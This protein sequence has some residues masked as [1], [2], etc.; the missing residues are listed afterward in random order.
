MGR[1]SHF[2]TYVCAV[3]LAVAGGA[4]CEGS[5]PGGNTGLG[6]QD[7]ISAGEQD[8]G[9]G[10]LPDLGGSGT[11]TDPGGPTPCPA[12]A[13]GPGTKAEDTDGDGCIDHCSAC[14]DVTC[15]E[16]EV[17]VDLDEDGCVD[18]CE[19]CPDLPCEA[20]AA[21]DT[22]EDG[23]PDACLPCE[24]FSCEGGQGALDSDG[25]GCVDACEDCPVT[26]PCPPGSM[27][28]DTDG[29]GCVDGCVDCLDLSCPPG[30]LGA[31]TDGNGCPDTCEP[32]PQILCPFATSALDEDGDGCDD[33]CAPCPPLECDPGLVAVDGD[34]DGCPDDCKECP[35]L[36]CGP[37][38]AAGDVD[39]D[40][41]VD[42]CTAC[43]PMEPCWPGTIPADLDGDG[44][45][46]ECTPCVDI[47]CEPGSTAVDTNGDGCD[48]G[49]RA[50]AQILCTPGTHPTDVDGDGCPDRCQLCPRLEC[51]P[52]EAPV[53]A[54][55]DRC[56]DTCKACEVPLCEPGSE[57]VDLDGDGC[58]ETCVSCQ[59]LPC[60]GGEFPVDTDGDGCA[61]ECA[62]CAPV[63]CRPGE[64]EID[65]DG[66]GCVDGCKPCDMV[67]CPP[68]TSAEDTDGDGCADAC[69]PCRRPLCRPGTLPVD[70]DGDGCRDTC[71]PCPPLQCREGT[72]PVDTDDD[73]CHDACRPCPGVLCPEGSVPVD[74]DGDSCE[75][76]CAPCGPLACPPD[77]EARDTDG[78]GCE[79]ACVPRRCRSNEDCRA[80]EY[81][82][83]RPGQCDDAGTCRAR[84]QA[85]T[86]ELDP[87]CG[88][89]GE[90]YGNACEAAVAGTGILHKGRCERECGAVSG[91]ICPDGEYCDLEPGMCAATGLA[92]VCRSV[93]E[94]CLGLPVAPV[95][96]CN[97]KTH[98]N[99]C[100]RHRAQ[101]QKMHDGPCSCEPL[102]C[103]HGTIPADTDNDACPDTC[104][105]CPLI[106]C[107]PGTVPVDVDGDGCMDEC[108]PCEEILC[109]DGSIPA[110]TD[111][112][113]CPDSCERLKCETNRDCPRA[114]Y[115]AAA[116]T[117]DCGSP[118]LCARR[119]D[120]CIDLYSPVCGCDGLTYGNACS[121]AAAG[122]RVMSRGE[123]ECRPIR[124]PDGSRPADTDGDGCDDE[125]IPC[126]QIVCL[127][128]TEPVD[129]NDD[130]CADVCTAPCNEQC[131]CYYNE[132]LE[133]PRPCPQ[134]CADCG[135]FWTCVEGACV[136][137]CGRIPPE[138]QDCVEPGWCE[139]NGD[140]ADFEIC[141]REPGRCEGP[142]WCEPRPDGCFDFYA[143]VCG[144]NGQTYENDCFASAEGQNV[145]HEG[146]CE[147]QQPCGGF[148]G[149]PCPG[150]Q[151]CD[152]PPGL[153]FI[154]D[155]G[156]VC[157]ERPDG[158]DDVWE[159]VCSCD[160]ETYPNDC[161]RLMQGAAK[162]HDGPCEC[163][164]ILC[165][166][167]TRPV[168][169]DFDGC[170]DDCLPCRPVDC[171]AGTVPV[172]LN[173][174]GCDDDCEPCPEIVCTGGMPV[175]FDGDGCDDFCMPCPPIECAPG[176]IPVDVD[177]DGCD[178]FCRPTRCASNR[179]CESDQ[180]CA[181]AV[182][183]CEGTGL[184]RAR[185]GTCTLE[186]DPVCGCDGRTYSNACAAAAKGVNVAHEGKCA[187]QEACGG[188]LGIE[189][190]DGSFCE[191]EPGTCL[192]FDIVGSC[193]EIPD[194]CTE[195]FA[196][197]CGCD[198]ETYGNDCERRSFGVQKAYDGPCEIVC[199]DV[200]IECADGLFP[201]DEDGDGCLDTCTAEC[202]EM[203]D[204]YANED[205][206]FSEPCLLRCANCGNSWQ[207]NEGICERRCGPIPPEVFECDVPEVCLRT[208]DCRDGTFCFKDDGLCKEEGV[209]LSTPEFCPPYVDPVCGCDG[210]TYNNACE[211][212]AFG[213]SVLSQGPCGCRPINC[214]EGEPVDTDG[215][216]CADTCLESPCWENEHC[217]P[218][219]YCHRPEGVCEGEGWCEPVPPVCPSLYAP[220]CGCDGETWPNACIANSAGVGVLHEGACECMGEVDCEPGF[221]PVDIDGDGCADECVAKC[222][223]VCDCYERLGMDF[224]TPCDIDCPFPHCGNFW[225]CEESRCVEGC[226]VIPD[227]ARQCMEERACEVNEDCPDRQY[228][229]R[230]AGTCN[231]P[232]RCTD[233]PPICGWDFQ[234]VCGCD[235][236]TYPN[237]CSANQQGVNVRS[238][239]ECETGE[240]ACTVDLPC[241]DPSQFCE[242]P[243]GT[244]GENGAEGTCTPRPLMCDFAEDSPVCGCDGMTY[245]SDCIRQLRGTS[246]LHEGAC[247]SDIPIPFP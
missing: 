46:E 20:G 217:G 141:A 57:P 153:C 229:A 140:C 68:E 213:V 17:A 136:A 205:L 246:L 25:D 221:A 24:P 129:R 236:M 53:D 189:C 11:R 51:E 37:G 32:C 137:R 61:D 218:G 247:G 77:Q 52:G 10:Q 239:G 142:G 93:P 231:G 59:P 168:D 76:A 139:S 16:G 96:D 211:A 43:L 91:F 209:C 15:E 173:G 127:P 240:E 184:C 7:G 82:A 193:V 206:E 204:C 103:E 245:T 219:G 29:D 126:P 45:P 105:P 9:T 185:P 174:D 242:L 169:R 58:P 66:D 243:A 40:G 23:C 48:D 130:G 131:D 207:C 144:C 98:K 194:S 8:G 149:Q 101:V 83:P 220:V 65:E 71:V 63:S 49:C 85:C 94:S 113:G 123:C 178:D 234:P 133:F 86:H 216:G 223:G 195:E 146:L 177:G 3:T 12:F 172:D 214:V 175:D 156:G 102:E 181:R 70:T 124:C 90:T 160:G 36:E 222:E 163:N 30:E 182:G 215:D 62:G 6:L 39:G 5:A 227:E 64:Q 170:D 180:Y 33:A 186:I 152:P 158:C 54:D 132:A 97:G 135:N 196:P 232:G 134:P 143:P 118:G 225:A 31:D 167:G 192:G 202:A 1:S 199:P 147:E 164:P 191:F 74:T 187:E 115:C 89:D 171:P 26:E 122:V 27:S 14:P 100:E 212:N 179:D 159:P 35:P 224:S 138:A 79:D 19:L 151:I 200:E 244:C 112:D 190:P 107:R 38:E 13:C 119:P 81:C 226:G 165:P 106:D 201:I 21:T 145:A 208:S 120:A 210:V 72:L 42:T 22:D 47:H 117:G 50:C 92:G 55:G 148:V 84:P 78:D 28:A 155:I 230:T 128:G 238:K 75:D 99:D 34:S 197:V 176:T 41:C 4:G 162:S 166:P 237:A 233:R 157:V 125:C 18:R 104:L 69:V 228:C 203:C 109:A 60:E 44:C 121:A 95:C 56:P 154:F 73:G 108:Q 235:G 116:R 241:A 110:D 111:G 67:E 88:C 87:V 2:A 114:F 198:D 188:F 161:E 80:G 150:D 183:R